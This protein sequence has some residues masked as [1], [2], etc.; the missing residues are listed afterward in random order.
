[1]AWGLWWLWDRF[2]LEDIARKLPVKTRKRVGIILLSGG[3]HSDHHWIGAD[4]P[5]PR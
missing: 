2:L 3:G 4:V 5:F 1:M